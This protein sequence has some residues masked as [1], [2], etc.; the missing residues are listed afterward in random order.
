MSAGIRCGTGANMEFIEEIESLMS[1]DLSEEALRLSRS[2]DLNQLCQ[3]M[4]LIYRIQMGR[5]M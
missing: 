5:P 4:L 3:E 2:R 1:L